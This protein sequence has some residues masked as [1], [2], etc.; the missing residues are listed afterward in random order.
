MEARGLISELEGTLVE[1]SKTFHKL[2][3]V[4]EKGTA[5]E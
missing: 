1:G 2:E 4:L 5:T 3:E